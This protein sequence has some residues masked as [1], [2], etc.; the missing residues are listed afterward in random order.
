M[1]VAGLVLFVDGAVLVIMES[2][3]PARLG[4]IMVG[5]ALIIAGAIFLTAQTDIKGKKEG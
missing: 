4:W 2:L 5:F 3:T 1:R